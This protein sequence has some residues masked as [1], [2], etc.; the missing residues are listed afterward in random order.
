MNTTYEKLGFLFNTSCLPE[1]YIPILESYDFYFNDIFGR[2]FIATENLTSFLQNF[3][4]LGFMKQCLLDWNFEQYSSV[5]SCERK[6]TQIN[7]GTEI[8]PEAWPL[9]LLDDVLNQSYTFPSNNNM[10]DLWIL[11]TGI[12]WKHKEFESG[13]VVDM[14]DSFTIDNIT[15]PHGTG[16]ACAAAGLNYGT[17]KHIPI[18]NFPVCKYNGN[19]G[20]SDIEKGLQSVLE[21][22][23]QNYKVG[24]RTV[25]NMSFGNYFGTNVMDSALGLYYNS[26]FEN[27]T[28]HGGIVVVSAG[29]SNEDACTWFYSYSPFV[30]S[31]GSL[32]R[33][34]DK[35]AFSNYGNCVDIW[36]FGSNVPVAYSVTN[37][38]T[39][40]Y[41]SGTS[42]SGPYI[43]GLIVNLLQ[44]NMNWS[45]DE[46]LNVLS[47][48]KHKLVTAK[49]SCGLEYKQCCTSSHF[50]TRLDAYCRSFP[51]TNCPRT[52]KVT[53]CR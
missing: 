28:L 36:F 39:I 21:H 37:S 6:S 27:I 3:D 18:Y 15:H 31:V 50:G 26:L 25:I 51:I 12:N 10:V 48:M 35:S 29:N 53:S 8:K 4:D 19:C 45:K 34:Y 30:I 38:T 41:K 46:L 7:Y 43:A 52:C 13:Q 24:K 9:D 17:S 44:N 42:F 20:S 49:Y 1:T 14:D 40:Q 2:G 11:D 23:I 47:N 22:T 5:L 16:T 33:N 32:D